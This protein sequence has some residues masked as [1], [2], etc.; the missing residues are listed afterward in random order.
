MGLATINKEQSWVKMRTGIKF[1]PPDSAYTVRLTGWARQGNRQGAVPV[2]PRLVYEC[3]VYLCLVSSRLQSTSSVQSWYV[4]QWLIS[5]FVREW[6]HG[7]EKCSLFCTNESGG[8][9][10]CCV[11]LRLAFTCSTRKWNSASYG[12][13]FVYFPVVVNVVCT[14]PVIIS[15]GRCIVLPEETRRIKP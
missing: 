14:L 6:K 12:G 8:K 15:C 7:N 1:S 9:W 3:D 10:M 2:S 13:R 11:R 5:T 4:H